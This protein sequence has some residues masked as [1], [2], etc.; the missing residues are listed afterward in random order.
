MH[1]IYA[2][3]AQSQSIEENL[4]SMGI[5]LVLLILTIGI[6]FIYDKFKK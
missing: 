4:I 6:G 2:K 1:Y 3:H 5:C